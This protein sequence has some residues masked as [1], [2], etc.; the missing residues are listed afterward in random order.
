MGSIVI[1]ILLW[2]NVVCL[3]SARGWVNYWR[4]SSHGFN[5][6]VDRNVGNIQ[7]SL[8]NGQIAIDV[9]GYSAICERNSV[10]GPNDSIDDR[11][12]SLSLRRNGF[13][14]V[15]ITLG[16]YRG[17][18]GQPKSPSSCGPSPYERCKGLHRPSYAGRNCG[19]GWCDTRIYLWSLISSGHGVIASYSVKVRW[20]VRIRNTEVDRPPAH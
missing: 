4:R 9:V 5:S 6:I 16:I 12:R 1:T 11:L 14:L 18:G 13:T 20:L 19:G 7:G 15:L 10:E 3:V 17:A 2:Q 8:Q